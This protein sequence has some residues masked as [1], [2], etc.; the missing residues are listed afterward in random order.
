MAARVKV[1]VS[2]DAEVARRLGETSRRRRMPKSRV[3][4][5]AL[6]LMRE[7]QL[8]RELREGYEAMA[9]EDLETA[10]QSIGAGR[11]VLE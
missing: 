1:T 8:E 6:E 4:E 11:E 7:R 9:R 2:L 5:E 3:V 10:E